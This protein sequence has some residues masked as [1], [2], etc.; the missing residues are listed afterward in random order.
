MYFLPPPPQW[1]Q[2][3]AGETN[4]QYSSWALS[5]VIWGRGCVI[6]PHTVLTQG[7]PFGTAVNGYSNPSWL[8]RLLVKISKGAER[9]TWVLLEFQPGFLMS[10]QRLVCWR[11]RQSTGPVWFW[12]PRVQYHGVRLGTRAPFLGEGHGRREAGPATQ[13]HQTNWPLLSFVFAASPSPSILNQQSSHTD[14]TDDI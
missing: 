13:L 3:V 4:N 10:S 14:L 6:Q 8:M 11:D 5:G 2:V 7:D 12:T 9:R 1:K